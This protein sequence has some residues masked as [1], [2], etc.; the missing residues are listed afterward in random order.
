MPYIKQEHREKL[1][2]LLDALIIAINEIDK[3]DNQHL[4]HAGILNYCCTKLTLE[5]IPVRSYWAIALKCG[6]LRN[7]ADEY[8]QRYARKYE[9]E[10]I[11]QNGDIEGYT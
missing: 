5:L 7:I 2:P 9:D 8:Y 6:I 1:K 10:K 3:G 11:I 4:S